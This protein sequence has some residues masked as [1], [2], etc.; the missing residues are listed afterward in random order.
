MSFARISTDN[1]V[2]NTITTAHDAG[3]M[4][5]S[6]QIFIH[7]LPETSPLDD[8]AG[9]D[10]LMASRLI[11][12]LMVLKEQSATQP[13]LVHLQTPGGSYSE[14]MAIYDTIRFMPF[15][16]TMLVYTHARSMS[17]IILQAADWR[18]MMPESYFMMHWGD[19]EFVGETRSIV[20][21]VDF[22][23]DYQHPRMMEIYVDKARQG[24]KFRGWS[25]SRVNSYLQKAME[26]EGDC[27]LP[28]SEAVKWGL[29][30][31]VFDGDWEGLLRN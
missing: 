9:V 5:K 19:M 30:D 8:Q 10:Y 1:D 26:K 3:I 23:K 18:V 28:A 13:V 22:M 12:N 16:V 27:F 15:H 2:V 14:G 24:S 31:E 7:S 17:S 4:P 20:S 25:S 21:H 11:K 6:R 29:A